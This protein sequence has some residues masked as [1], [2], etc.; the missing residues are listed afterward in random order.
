MV[1]ILFSFKL[2][3]I[4]INNLIYIGTEK[5]VVM[6]ENLALLCEYLTVCIIVLKLNNRQNNH[7]KIHLL[8]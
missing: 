1:F 7:T 2:F 8:I 3:K 5:L 4:V 6:D